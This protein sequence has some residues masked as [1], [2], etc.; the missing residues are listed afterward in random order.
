MSTTEVRQYQTVDGRIPVAMWLD[1][2]HDRAARTR[3]L[4]RIDRLTEGLR[5]DWKSLRGGIYELRIDYG[6]GYRVYYAQDG[7]KLILLLCA[8]T[9]RTQAN[10][11][12]KARE[13]WKD[14]ETRSA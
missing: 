3:I 11:I 1:H 6:P 12:E 14:Y 7:A 10:D 5:G 9:K 4:A 2:L 8:G 13:Y